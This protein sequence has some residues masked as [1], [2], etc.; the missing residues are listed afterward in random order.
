VDIRIINY[1]ISVYEERSF[2]KAAEKV[3]VVQSA[4]SMQIRNLE[5]ELGAAL[6]ERNP[7]GVEPT[8]A[9]RRFYELCVPVAR[10]IA[11]AKQEILDLV[12]GK[13]VSGSL[14][15]GLPSSVSRGILGSVLTEFSGQYPNV[16]LTVMEA[17][18]RVLTEQVQAGV[19]DVA[20]A[21]MPKE[22][23]G[24]SFR[25]SFQDTCV[26][27]SGEPVNGESFTTCDLF[28]RKDLK[29]VIPS[30][31]HLLGAAMS[32]Y[33]TSGQITPQRLMKIDGTIAAMES[34]VNSD[35]AALCPMS[36]VI[37]DLGSKKLFFYPIVNPD[38]KFDLYLLHDQRRP[39]TLA[40]RCFVEILEKKL[41]SV[42]SIW[43]KAARA[44]SRSSLKRVPSAA[45]A[46]G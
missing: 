24:L 4:L 43:A 46:N 19:L 32:N 22:F 21:A 13:C 36:T 1:F 40:A 3:H 8:V 39:L 14:R 20:L 34:V 25:P 10:D 29:L 9:G 35:W 23:S 5:D 11:S 15:I 2:T 30:E 7:R 41:T 38:I 6:F 33:I 45:K 17:Y 27:V 42:P 31:R 18:H 28:V 16:D 26:L 12:Q 37:N 44:G